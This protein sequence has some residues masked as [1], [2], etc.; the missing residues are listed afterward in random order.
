MSTPTTPTTQPST[1]AKPATPAPSTR[2]ARLRALLGGQ[3]RITP[4]MSA[5]VTTTTPVTP[6]RSPSMPAAEPIINAATTA[7]AP[8]ANTAPANPAADKAGDAAPKPQAASVQELEA[9]FPGE[10]AFV[11]EQFRSGAT[12]LSAHRAFAAQLKDRSGKAAAQ[13]AE[14]TQRDA[15]LTSKAGSSAGIPPVGNAAPQ[16]GAGAAPAGDDGRQSE[17]Y[18][19]A[20]QLEATGVNRITALKMAAKKFGIV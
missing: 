10:P 12:L 13:L 19:Y 16:A 6:S 4:V 5:P 2:F 20:K 17:A 8:A 9:E 11:L 1:A 3:A 14:M 7:T 15:D 18:L